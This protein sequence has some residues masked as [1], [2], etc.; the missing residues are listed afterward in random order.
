MD[1]ED[2]EYERPS[3]SALK[4]EADAI[5]KLGK[6]LAGLSPGQLTRVPLPDDIR[7]AVQ[8]AQKIRQNVAKKR[9]FQFLAKL[10]RGADTEAITEELD[11]I[12]KGLPSL[13]SIQEKAEKAAE[14]D[15]IP[16]LVER[17][18]QDGDNAIQALMEDHPDMDRSRLRQLLRNANKKPVHDS[19]PM[20]VLHDY[21]RE[22][23]QR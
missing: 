23:L 20:K 7:A 5:R 10:L 14:P 8:E 17:L 12:E 9:H 6:T 1:F 2:D 15:P 4:R 22:T 11:R 16:P 21:L 3:K 19:K 13:A 18:M